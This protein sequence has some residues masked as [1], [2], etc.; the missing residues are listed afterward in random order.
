VLG[1][2]RIQYKTAEQ[3]V[4][5]RRAGL[6]VADALDAVR[7][8]LRPGVSTLELDRVAEDVIRTAGATP[9]FLG[10]GHPP[11]PA[12]TCISVNDEIVHG[13]PGA[14][15]IRP[16]DV[17]SVDCGAIL[18]GW[19]GDAAFTAVLP[20]ADGSVDPQDAALVE[21][22]EQALWHGIAAVRVGERLNAVGAAVEDLV[23]GRYGLVEEYGG[24][25]IGTEMHQDPHVLNYRTR[26][27]GPRLRA[28]ICLAVEPMLTRGD[29]S[30]RILA[31]EWTVSTQDGQNAA[32]WEH[33]V[34]LTAAGPWVLT[35]RDGGEQALAAIGVQVTPGGD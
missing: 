13:I 19:H 2:D 10:Y 32:H 1:R 35:A 30:T 3:I 26:E 31:D 33:T 11:F 5:M 14:R 9:S 18:A 12:S 7:A 22:T 25:G 21:V 8:A 4:L 16:G 27:R 28:G 29:P 20:G 15:V 24:H 6:V 17:V 23:D 34:A